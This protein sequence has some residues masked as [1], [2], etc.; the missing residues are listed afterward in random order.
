MS[1][2]VLL[3]KVM[4]AITFKWEES[5]AL[6]DAIDKKVKEIEECLEEED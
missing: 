1:N 2:D 5:T 3:E 6:Y 4:R